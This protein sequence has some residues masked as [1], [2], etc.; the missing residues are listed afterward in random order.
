MRDG[1]GPSRKHLQQDAVADSIGIVLVAS[2]ECATKLD[3]PNMLLG[4]TT[5]QLMT[6]VTE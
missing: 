1:L 2:D 6:E 3:V 5:S 4:K